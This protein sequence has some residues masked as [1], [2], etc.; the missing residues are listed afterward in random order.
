MDRE[1]VIWEMEMSKLLQLFH[2]EASIRGAS[3][4]WSNFFEPEPELLAK[5]EEL[6]NTEPPTIC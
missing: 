4:R 2:V 5:F 1:H 3:L 6:A